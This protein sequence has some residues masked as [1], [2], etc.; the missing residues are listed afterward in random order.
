MKV[1]NSPFVK[2]L[3][4][5]KLNR[6]V[7]AV[8]EVLARLFGIILVYVFLNTVL[9]FFG[10][11][12]SENDLMVSLLILPVL[13]ILKDS[14]KVVEPFTISASLHETEVTVTRGLITKVTDTLELPT[15]D[16]IEI[17]K[18]I[19]G[20][21]YNHASIRLIAPGGWVEIPHLYDFEN[22]VDHVHRA[23]EKD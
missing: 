17:T 3:N 21:V 12:D 20:R 7:E 18:T 16:N 22:L 10:L 9:I 19:L 11:L 4:T 1:Q 5:A 6:C 14:Y 15:I 23:K 8:F 2:H 13:Y